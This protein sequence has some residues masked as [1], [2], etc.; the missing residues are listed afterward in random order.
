MNLQNVWF[1]LERKRAGHKMIWRGAVASLTR[2]L[3]NVVIPFDQPLQRSKIRDKQSDIMK[4][5]NAKARRKRHGFR[6]KN[7]FTGI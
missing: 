2:Q 1:G 5:E 4:S 7:E 3:A 6:E